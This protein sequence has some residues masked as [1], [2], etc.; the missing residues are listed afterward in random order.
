MKKLIAAY[1][2][3]CNSNDCTPYMFINRLFYYRALMN[4]RFDFLT[5]FS[6]L[7]WQNQNELPDSLAFTRQANIH[8]LINARANEILDLASALN[9][10]IYV[11]WSGGVDS[12]CVVTALL[13]NKTNQVIELI[14]TSESIKDNPSFACLMQK[15]GIKIHI[16]AWTKIQSFIESSDDYIITNGW[17]ADQLFG[18]RMLNQFPDLY[19]ADWKL[20]AFYIYKNNNQLDY[21]YLNRQSMSILDD[22]LSSVFPTPI[23]TFSQVCWFFNFCMKWTFIKNVSTMEANGAYY[24]THNIPF[25]I[26]KEFS[27]WACHRY[28]WFTHNDYSIDPRLYKPELKSYTIDYTKDQS[29][30][31]MTKKTS[32]NPMYETVTD[33]RLTVI[34][35]DGF[36]DYGKIEAKQ[37]YQFLLTHYA[38]E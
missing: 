28:D 22:Y 8:D 18:F 34:D 5:K 38:K 13:K 20:G 4:D 33:N 32:W 30:W 35:S 17:G 1:R 26:T 27:D 6:K 10:K 16:L 11:L 25:F 15:I 19:N 2:A 29:F 21:Y 7:N 24:I 3:V 9:K 14:A 36:K 37:K 31:L 12:T 23:K